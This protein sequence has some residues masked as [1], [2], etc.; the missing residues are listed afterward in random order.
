[1][2]AEGKKEISGKERGMNPFNAS[3]E[4]GGGGGMV[5]GEGAVR[6]GAPLR[7]EKEGEGKM[8]LGGLGASL[9]NIE[10]A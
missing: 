8:L 1:L 4:R 2:A 9:L 7:F 3:G 5:V 10:K 6:G